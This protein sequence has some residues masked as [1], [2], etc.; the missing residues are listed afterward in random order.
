MQWH[1]GHWKREAALGA[2]EWQDGKL[3]FCDSFPVVFVV[4]TEALR[5]HRLFLRGH[6]SVGVRLSSRIVTEEWAVFWI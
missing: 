2:R 4:V 6:D 1:C 5:R 3:I